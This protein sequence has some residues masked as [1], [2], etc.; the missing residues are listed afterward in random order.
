MQVDTMQLVS[1][2]SHGLV[3]RDSEAE[4]RFPPGS[5]TGVRWGKRPRGGGYRDYAGHVTLRN[6]YSAIRW[7]K[8]EPALEFINAE[9][10]H[11]DYGGMEPRQWIQDREIDRQYEQH[12]NEPRRY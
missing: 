8:P 3:F 9:A 6:M 5:D 4:Y 10:P 2:D 12:D 11:P 1:N 7:P